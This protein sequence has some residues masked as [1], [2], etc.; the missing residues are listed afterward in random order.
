VVEWQIRGTIP[1]RMFGQTV[2][3]LPTWTNNSQ[4]P[5]RKRAVLGGGGGGTKEAK[6]GGLPVIFQTSWNSGI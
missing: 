6:A 2:G 4:I 5:Y 3:F 1:R